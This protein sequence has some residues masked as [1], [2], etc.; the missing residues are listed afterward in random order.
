MGHTGHDLTHYDAVEPTPLADGNIEYW[1]CG[2]CGAAFADED[3]TLPLGLNRWVLGATVDNGVAT[4]PDS[5]VTIP[6]GEDIVIDVS[7]STEDIESVVIGSETL[8]KIVDANTSLEIKLSDASVSFDATALESISTQAGDASITIIVNQIDDSSLTDDQ[9]AALED[10]NVYLIL[11]VEVYAGD[12]QISN[13]NG[14]KVTVSVP[15]EVPEGK[16]A[17]DYYIAYVADDGTIT[18]LPT[19]YADG[20]L[21]FETT[22]FSNYV[23]LEKVS[24]SPDTSDSTTLFPAVLIALLGITGTALLTKKRIFK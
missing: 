6:D 18:A 19:T 16:S 1:R 24:A 20:V 14:G 7:D 9:V 12:I 17:S 2:T 5:F 10:E 8:D 22:R 11:T 3:A 15:F 21:S 13:F 23:V 4:I